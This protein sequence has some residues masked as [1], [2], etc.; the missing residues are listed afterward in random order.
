MRLS[1][2]LGPASRYFPAS[3][4]IMFHGRMRPRPLPRRRWVPGKV[5]FCTGPVRVLADTVAAPE[6][7]QLTS[8]GC[9]RKRTRVSEYLEK[10]IDSLLYG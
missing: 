9:E 4:L 8:P 7:L 1:P 2:R 5:Y 10:V 3:A 6:A